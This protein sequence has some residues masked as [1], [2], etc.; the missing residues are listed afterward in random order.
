MEEVKYSADDFAGN[1]A[2]VFGTTP[3]A[4]RTALK[5][6]GVKEATVEEAKAIVKNFL[7]SEVK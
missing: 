6:A 3:E 2:K 4:V 5:I 7:E 1:A